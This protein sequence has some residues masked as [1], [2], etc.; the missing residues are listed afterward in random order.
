MDIHTEL[1]QRDP[2]LFINAQLI[3]SPDVFKVYYK[4]NDCYLMLRKTDLKEYESLD[5]MRKEVLLC[6]KLKHINLLS[7][8]TS[9][10][11]G[12]DLW[13]LTP[14]SVFGSLSDVSKPF[15]LTEQ[16][17]SLVVKDVLNGVQYL[18]NNSIVHHSI[19]ASH[20]LVLG[21]P[22]TQMRCVLSGLKYSVSAIRE[23]KV[24]YPMYDFPVHTE[25][26]INWMAPE[27]LE[28]NMMGYDTKADIYSIGITCC[29][30]CNGSIPYRG[31]EPS[32]V[33]LSKLNGDIPEPLDS[34]CA[35]LNQLTKKGDNK[36]EINKYLE[37]KPEEK[38]RYESFLQRTYSKTF[39]EFVIKCCLHPEPHK[40]YNVTQLLGHQFITNSD[41]IEW[42]GGKQ[43]QNQVLLD[44][45]N[46][47]GNGRSF[48]L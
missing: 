26:Y 28:Q 43:N 21:R 35:G 47:N 30:L 7:I 27:V 32:E 34:T 18:H 40:R 14:Y 8:I 6:H 33:L 19:K 25:R 10:T 13:T 1:I 45:F 48:S 23:G 2:K 9:F 3:H 38:L 24:M 4:P 37:S 41:W 22:D 39:K 17:I 36:E 42:F 11:V 5:F 46:R 16:C 12:S 31:L 20:I 29:E 44:S 15:G